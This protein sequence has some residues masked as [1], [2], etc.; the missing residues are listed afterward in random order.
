MANNN[1]DTGVAF[2]LGVVGGITLGVIWTVAAGT[3]WQW[4]PILGALGAYKAVSSII[5][6]TYDDH[7]KKKPKKKGGSTCC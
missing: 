6:K 7:E 3:F 2:P 4:V 1:N 5:T